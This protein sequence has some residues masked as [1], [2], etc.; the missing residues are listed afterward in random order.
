ML[1]HV[2]PTSVYVVPLITRSKVIGVIA[3]DAID[4]RGIPFET[5]ET[6][7]VF[8]PQIAI[9]IENAR[10]YSRLQKQMGK[11]LQQ[12]PKTDGGAEKISS[13]FESLRKILFFG[14]PCGKAGP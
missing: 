8:A 1:T 13:P 4:G 10:L 5:R 7:E 11:T 14:Q 9:A 3:T 12:T 2:K 6:L